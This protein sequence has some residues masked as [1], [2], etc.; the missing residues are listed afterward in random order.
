MLGT[1]G[2]SPRQA[3]GLVRVILAIVSVLA[4]ASYVLYQYLPDTFSSTSTLMDVNGP[5]VVQRAMVSEF[6]HHQKE[7]HHQHLHQHSMPKYQLSVRQESRQYPFVYPLS[8]Y[9]HA[10][11]AMAAKFR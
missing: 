4:L 7:S 6:M 8:R 2:G 10:D 5:H 11:Q 1:S 9:E 3:S